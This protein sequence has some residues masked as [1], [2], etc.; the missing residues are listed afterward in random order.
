M[1]FLLLLT[2]IFLLIT[3][4][5]LAQNTISDDPPADLPP[6]ARLD[7][8]TPV[9]Q[10]PNR[11][12]AAALTIQLSY[13]GWEGTYADTISYL[14]PNIEDVSV[15][16]EEMAAFAGRNGLWSIIRTGGTIELLQRLVAGGFPVLIENVYYDG[17]DGWNDWMSHN[18]VMMGYDLATGELYFYDSLLGFGTDNAGRVMSYDDVLTRWRPFN[19]NYLVLYRPEEEDALR[20][21][22][23]DQWDPILNAEH[24]LAMAE[25]DLNGVY[26]DSF[27]LFNKASTL[28]VLER[29]EEAA[30]VFDQVFALGLPPR[31]LW[32]QFGPFEA[33]L[34]VERYQ[35]VLNLSARVIASTPGVEEVY[36]Y[37]GRAYEALG[38]L[39]RA[40]ANYEVA[41][42]RNANYSEAVDALSRVR[43]ALGSS[44]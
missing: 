7:G 17:N 13:F 5:T 42:F 44:G 26:N 38:D 15:R 24:T 23:G 14:N 43:E 3:G 18:R 28:L 37:A 10:Q 40:Q 41:I 39:T 2:G 33:Y 6:S 31:F 36:Y 12:S 4:S 27:S 29:Y 35:D 20:A 30:E 22:L 32:Y 21:I 11:C 9:W 19:Y 16:L 34:A 1:R 25:A 8:L